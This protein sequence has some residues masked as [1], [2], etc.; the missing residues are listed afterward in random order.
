MKDSNQVTY[1]TPKDA[2]ILE[3]DNQF[4]ADLIEG[5]S[6]K[7]KSIPSKYFYDAKGSEL[8]VEITK[9]PEYYLSRAEYEI[10]E[11]SVGMLKALGLSKHQPFNLI[12][13]GSGDGNKTTLLI[14]ELTA[15]QYSFEYHPI[16][17]SSSSLNHLKSRLV[18]KYPMISLETH[19]GE[20]LIE[21]SSL[22][23]SDKPKVVLFLGSSLGNFDDNQ[24]RNFIRSISTLL[25][26]GD[27]L[28]LGL[29]L[30]KPASVVLP[31]YDDSQ[32]IT[33]RFNLNLL[34]R[35]NSEL[36]ANFQLNN[37]EHLATYDENVGIAKS[38]LKSKKNQTFKLYEGSDTFSLMKGE[39]IATEISRKYN[40]S[41]IEE[42]IRSSGMIN[43]TEIS[44]SKGLFSVF[45][46]EKV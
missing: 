40:P 32:G 1:N 31:A 41:I 26:S 30:I 46:F 12:E 42:I 11:D 39:L 9:L 36:G 20:F 44:D 21:L 3:K 18:N 43:R 14:N 16:D 25:S 33:A 4:K 17:I 7:E 15:R 8:F 24:A 10:F 22:A 45:I 38:F 13:L 28:A 34:R 23:L 2:T 37:F 5:L 29:D 35:A 27:K 6:K 19:K